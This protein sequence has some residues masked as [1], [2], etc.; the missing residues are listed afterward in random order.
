MEEGRIKPQEMEEKKV[1]RGWRGFNRFVCFRTTF[2]ESTQKLRK[3]YV[4]TII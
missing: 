4:D 3:I 1:S 2:F